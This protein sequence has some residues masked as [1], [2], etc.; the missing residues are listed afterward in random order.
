MT[1]DNWLHELEAFL[2]ARADVNGFNSNAYAY[3]LGYLKSMFARQ[4]ANRPEMA[5]EVTK[6]MEFA[7]KGV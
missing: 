2:N 6:S 7:L 4:L 5:R 1:Y 3:K